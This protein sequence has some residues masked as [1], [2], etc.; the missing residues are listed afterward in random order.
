MLRAGFLARTT[1]HG[2]PALAALFYLL[3]HRPDWKPGH[4]AIGSGVALVTA[5][6]L[7]APFPYDDYQAAVYPAL[8]LL[9]SLH[10][11]ARI[12]EA[13]RPRLAA[14]VGGV[15]LL[16]ALSSPQIQDWFSAGRDRI[17]WRVKPRPDL[18]VLR[19]T[20]RHLKTLDPDAETLL[21]TD[22]YLAVEAGLDV[23]RGLEMGPFSYFPDMPTDRA[24]RLRVLN[25]EQLRTLIR[26]T[27]A[28]LAAL[29]GYS[30]TIH[31]PAIT[32]LSADE[33]RR[34]RDTLETHYRPVST[35]HPFGQAGT[36]LEILRRDGNP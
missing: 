13:G 27:D 7:L 2:L 8:V 20:A 11:P 19:E 6:H 36:R 31:S 30:F 1:L 10:L 32:E 21:T 4:R 12:P 17:W 35:V 3:L 22:A 26:D 33:Q 16:F 23:P 9:V 18:A 24:A 14:A 15:C 29:S 5:L 25:P 34:I 28:P